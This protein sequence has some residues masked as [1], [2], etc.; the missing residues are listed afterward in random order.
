MLLR[1]CVD[2]GFGTRSGLKPEVARWM[3]IIFGIVLGLGVI[4][5]RQGRGFRGWVVDA[6]QTYL[7]M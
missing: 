4:T 7:T 3:G 6:K 1:R 2:G 5:R